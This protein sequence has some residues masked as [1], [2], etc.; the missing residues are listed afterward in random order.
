MSVLE[1]GTHDIRIDLEPR[2]DDFRSSR[3]LSLYRVGV[4]AVDNRVELCL[5]HSISSDGLSVRIY[6]PREL[7]DTV[8][9]ELTTGQVVSGIVGRMADGRAGLQMDGNVDLADVLPPGV[10]FNSPRHVENLRLT[11]PISSRLRPRDP[12]HHVNAPVVASNVNELNAVEALKPEDRA[13]IVIDKLGPIEGVV[14]WCR[15][16]FVTVA[17]SKP[18]P[19]IDFP[20]WAISQHETVEDNAWVR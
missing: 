5:V 18:I 11:I 6:A 3:H 16:Q 1:F 13:N 2:S 17:F 7:G 19:L 9:F 4:L 15:G 20:T 8:S 12:R 10:K 14:H